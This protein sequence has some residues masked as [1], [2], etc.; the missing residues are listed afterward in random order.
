[1]LI[2]PFLSMH[3]NSILM[4]INSPFPVTVWKQKIWHLLQCFSLI[5]AEMALLTVPDMLVSWGLI[6]NGS[7]DRVSSSVLFPD[8]LWTHPIPSQHGTVGSSPAGCSALTWIHCP[9]LRV[10]GI[11]TILV[12][13]RHHVQWNL[14]STLLQSTHN[15]FSPGTTSIKT[16]LNLPW[17]YVCASYRIPPVYEYI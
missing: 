16:A 6:K 3:Y 5:S 2:I 15:F 17:I 4:P 13:G 7:I 8:R 11:P 12:F 14:N 9:R 1:M 10:T